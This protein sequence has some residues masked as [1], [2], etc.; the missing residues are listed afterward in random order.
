MRTFTPLR[1]P[2]G[3][4]KLYKMVEEIISSNFSEP[5]VYVEPYAGGF[6]LGMKLLLKDKVSKVY[7][8]DADNAIYSFWKAII[9]YTE[10]FVYLVETADLSVN[11]WRRQK[12]IYLNENSPVLERGFATFYLNRTNR[13]G[14]LMAGP[15]GGYNQEGK[16][17]IDCR[18]NKKNLIKVI[19]AISQR[20]DDINIYNLDGIDLIKLVDSKEKNS[21]IYLDPPYVKKGNLLYKNAFEHEDHVELSNIIKTINNKWFVTYDNHSLIEEL[22]KDVGVLKFD[23]TYS[24]QI[25]R[26]EKE[27]AIFSPNLNI[28]NILSEFSQ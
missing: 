15:M 14:I 18:F 10:E 4:A 1:Y 17:K 23:I 19:N 11:E 26:K 24:A 28:D 5:P 12:E 22:Y 13:S 3:K 7:I 20:K 2:G 8:N 25:K 27:I 21:L 6:G 16:Y 9:D